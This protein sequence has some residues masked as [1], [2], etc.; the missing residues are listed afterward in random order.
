MQDHASLGWDNNSPKAVV[1][2]RGRSFFVA[3]R[4]EIR[5]H[6]DYCKSAM[7][8]FQFWAFSPVDR[9]RLAAN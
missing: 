1:N 7:T 4:Q 8:G 6:P 3:D 2:I 9:G 5:G